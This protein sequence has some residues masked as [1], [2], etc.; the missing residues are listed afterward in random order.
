MRW[1]RTSR[2]PIK[3]FLYSP[4]CLPA[5]LNTAPTAP[6]A[7]AP[8]PFL[9]SCHPVGSRGQAPWCF[10]ALYETQIVAPRTPNSYGVKRNKLRMSSP[11]HATQH[12]R[13]F[14]GARTDRQALGGQ[15]ST[16]GPRSLGPWGSTT[17]RRRSRRL[18][19]ARPPRSLPPTAFYLNSTA[20][21][22]SP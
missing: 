12:G 1:I 4:V 18:A 15:A 8:L 14:R 7:P 2:L 6:V 20:P 16:G 21:D 10:G 22:I 17:S 5:C 11:T 19:A 9:P 13:D 3:N